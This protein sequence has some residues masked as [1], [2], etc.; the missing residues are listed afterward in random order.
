MGGMI[1]KK[2]DG[3]T[4]LEEEEDRVWMQAGRREAAGL[5]RVMEMEG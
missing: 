4:R 2:R 3:L 1:K 5:K